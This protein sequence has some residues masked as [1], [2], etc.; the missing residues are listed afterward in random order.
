MRRIWRKIYDGV[1]EWIGDGSPS[2]T[3]IRSEYGREV[4][5]K[6]E[7]G[8]REKKERSVKPTDH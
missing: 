8:G 7:S 5:E 6:G 4:R 2:G 3:I 1:D